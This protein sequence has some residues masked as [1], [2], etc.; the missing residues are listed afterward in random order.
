MHTICQ[1]VYLFKSFTTLQ[2]PIPCNISSL[3]LPRDVNSIP[4]SMKFTLSKSQ[5]CKTRHFRFYHFILCHTLVFNFHFSRFH[6]LVIILGFPPCVYMFVRS[7]VSSFCVL[8][9][10]SL[11]PIPLSLTL[12]LSLPPSLSIS[13]P[14]CSYLCLSLS[15]SFSVYFHHLFLNFSLHF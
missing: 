8:V 7:V 9:F 15:F 13:I 12:L 2:S 4:L 5:L 6:S 3:S 1:S 11:L 14:L 10:Q